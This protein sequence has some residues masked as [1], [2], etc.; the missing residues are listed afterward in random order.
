M[1]TDTFDKATK[2]MEAITQ[3]R[4]SLSYIETL[5]EKVQAP[6]SR[7]EQVSLDI[8]GT[9]YEVILPNGS[10]QALLDVAKKRRLVELACLERE[11]RKL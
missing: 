7:D 8:Q 3:S 1:T 4:K 11:F 10:T 6:P 5:R 9:R 2:L